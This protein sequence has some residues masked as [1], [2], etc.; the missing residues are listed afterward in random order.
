MHTFRQNFNL[1]DKKISEDHSLH[2]LSSPV[3]TSATTADLALWED[4]RPSED[5]QSCL[6]VFLW[7]AAVMAT[8]LAVAVNQALTSSSADQ[9]SN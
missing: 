5:Q 8:V 9:P 6:N 7:Y 3:S 2:R 4:F 1:S